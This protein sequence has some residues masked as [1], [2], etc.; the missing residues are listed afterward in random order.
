MIGGFLEVFYRVEPPKRGVKQHQTA[1][2]VESSVA[3]L[4]QDYGVDF[5]QLWYA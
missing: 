5:A 4:Q 3:S 2:K 1:A